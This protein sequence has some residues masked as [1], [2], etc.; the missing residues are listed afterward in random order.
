MVIQE[1]IFQSDGQYL[2]EGLPYTRGEGYRS[3]VFGVLCIRGMTKY[4]VSVESP[5][6]AD[7]GFVRPRVGDL[8]I[9]FFSTQGHKPPITIITM[10]VVYIIIQ[11]YVY[12]TNG[13]HYRQHM[14][15]NAGMI[16]NNIISG[17]Y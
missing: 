13:E 12:H 8:F 4:I 5:Y 15:D 6:K 1:E 11:H 14:Y 7:H 17:S 3:E 10:Y 9:Y 2:M 16:D